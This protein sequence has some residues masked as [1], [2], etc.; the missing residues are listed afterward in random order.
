MRTKQDIY[1]QII[2]NVTMLI[3]DENDEIAIMA[4][5]ACE[6][7][8]SIDYYHWTGFY[9]CVTPNVLTIGPYQGTHGCLTIPF[10]RGICGKAAREK[11]TILIKDVNKVPDHIA[12]SSETRSEIAVPVFDN[13]NNIHSV[14]DADSNNEAAFNEIDKKYLEK[15]VALIS[16]KIFH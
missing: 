4:T 13:N 12:C 2:D 5:V 9:R 8:N 1:E 6:L 3:E 14:F 11:K 10:D 16:E 15:I 7:H